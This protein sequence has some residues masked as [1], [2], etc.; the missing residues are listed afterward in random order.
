M[1]HQTNGSSYDRLRPLLFSIAY[2]ML[3][4][5][6]DAEDIVQE[7]FLRLEHVRRK[8]IAIESERGFLT[9]VATRLAIDELRSAR[10]QR[11]RYFGPWL[12]EPLITAAEP[13]AAEV[14][15]LSDSLSI[16]FLVLLETLTPVERAVFLLREVF[17]YRYDEIAEIIDKSDVNCRQILTR[18]RKRI[19]AGKARFEVDREQQRELVTRFL[20]VFENGEL[21]QL[22]SLLAA[23]VVFYGDGGGKGQGLP[24]PIYGAD[25]VGRLLRSARAQFGQLGA[26]LEPASVNGEP[27]M[28]SLDADGRLINVFLFEIADGLIQ[29]I[30]SIINP[31]KL[32]HLGYPLSDLGRKTDAQSSRSRA[33]ATM[34]RPTQRSRSRPRS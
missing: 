1:S 3:G 27:G 28:L 23:D 17:D 22:V 15:E 18:A 7:A 13:D 32:N 26:R 6:D 16:S 25:R 4:T 19:D 20:D 5:V 30:R 9:T 8:G 10:A 21:D 31:D 33:F 14:A 2:R 24:R 12:P 29:T 34:R 11:Q